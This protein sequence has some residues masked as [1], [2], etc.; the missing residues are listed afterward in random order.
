MKGG[1]STKHSWQFNSSLYYV[2]A[3]T[4]NVVS[5]KKISSSRLRAFTFLNLYTAENIRTYKSIYLNFKQTN[6]Q[7]KSLITKPE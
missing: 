7:T 4:T 3:L 6:K 5:N 2:M 1:S